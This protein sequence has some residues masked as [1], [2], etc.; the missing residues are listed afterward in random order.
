MPRYFLFALIWPIFCLAA[1]PPPAPIASGV[2][3]TTPAERLALLQPACGS[4]ATD[5]GCSACPAGT[6]FPNDHLEIRG[7]IYGHFLGPRSDDAAVGFFGCESHADGFGGALLLTRQ[8]GAWKLAALRPAAIVDDCKKIAAR[9][10]RDVLVCYG[11]DMHQGIADKYLFLLDFTAHPD[12][13]NALDIFFMTLDSTAACTAITDP[14]EALVASRIDT[15]AFDSS[16]R[17]TVTASLGSITPDEFKP[18]AAEC[19][20]GDIATKSPGIKLATIPK[21]YTF[22]YAGSHVTPVQGNPPMS[23]NEAIAPHTRALVSKHGAR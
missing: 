5:K 18:L 3:E 4:R 13:E 19:E 10:G 8:N 2:V 1:Q 9:D 23:G 21:T 22:S 12:P 11:D 16:G 14:Q 17:I 15:V 6:D 7:V 20:A